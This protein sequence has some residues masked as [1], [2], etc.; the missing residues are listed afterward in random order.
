MERIPRPT[1]RR[2]LT[3]LVLLLVVLLVPL[4]A[5]AQ[6]TARERLEASA[7]WGVD[8]ATGAIAV[9]ASLLVLYD[10][11]GKTLVVN[12]NF[13]NDALAE[14]GATVQ[15]DGSW[16]M[17]DGNVVRPLVGR[18]AIVIGDEPAD[19]IAASGL[20]TVPYDKVT[21]TDSVG[22]VTT[23]PSRALV[24]GTSVSLP[25]ALRPASFAKK[26]KHSKTC[27]GCS[28][29]CNNGCHGN[30]NVYPINGK[31][32]FCEFKLFHR[33]YQYYTPACRE[34]TYECEGC[35]GAVVETYDYYL[36]QCTGGC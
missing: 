21:I 20:P 34:D 8:R 31:T 15:R 12:P 17:P 6:A 25:R 29:W 16:R 4:A 1:G 23:D 19:L 36:W 22:L 35:Q 32:G 18:E 30:A 33:C 7:G 10:P 2:L 24:S 14:T 28:T 11:V 3:L 9:D 26:I 5:T 27:A 13:W